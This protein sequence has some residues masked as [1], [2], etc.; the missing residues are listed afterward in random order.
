MVVYRSFDLTEIKEKTKS[1]IIHLFG[2]AHGGAIGTALEYSDEHYHNDIAIVKVT[3]KG[4]NLLNYDISSSNEGLDA[5]TES[6]SKLPLEGKKA[7]NSYQ[8]FSLSF[9]Q[10]KDKRR[11]YADY[12]KKGDFA[13]I[14]SKVAPGKQYIITDEKKSYVLNP[15]TA[16]NGKNVPNY[17]KGKIHI[18]PKWNDFVTSIYK[19]YPK[20]DVMIFCNKYFKSENKTEGPIQTQ[21]FGEFRDALISRYWI[22]HK[23]FDFASLLNDFVCS[24][25]G[26]G[27][28][29]K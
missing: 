12:L 21:N 25:V 18:P 11:L 4:V 6:S 1:N 23:S 24:Y 14:Y 16:L 27:N 13:V 17:R 10:N 26:N 15:D 20:S 22:N 29:K 9:S 8:Q 7:E 5:K 2:G 19:L 3:V 28:F